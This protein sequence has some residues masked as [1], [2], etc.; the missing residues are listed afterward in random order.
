MQ[1]QC[2]MQDTQSQC[3]GTTKNNSLG[4]EVGGRF[5]M[6]EHM[7]TGDWLEAKPE[8][9]LF[10]SFFLPSVF[11]AD[12][13]GL[14]LSSIILKEPRVNIFLKI[15]QPHSFLKEIWYFKTMKTHR[16]LFKVQCALNNIHIEV[17]LFFTGDDQNSNCS[18]MLRPLSSIQIC[19]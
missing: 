14:P 18:T 8:R 5:W 3:S 11:T 4:S 16:C 10:S 17:L 7:C 9:N 1:V 13:L 12:I 15:I 6:W 2:M 19:K